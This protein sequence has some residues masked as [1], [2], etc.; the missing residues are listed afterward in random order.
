[1]QSFNIVYQ[2]RQF[3]VIDKPSG[4]SVHRDDQQQG[5]TIRIA[6]QLG[7]ERVWLVHRLDKATSGLLIF[8]LNKESARVLSELFAQHKIQK[9]YLALSQ[10]KPKKKQGRIIGDMEKSRRGQWKLCKTKENPAITD[11]ISY[12][13]EPNLR[14]FILKPKTGKTHQLRVAMKSLG[15]PILG[16][17]LYDNKDKAEVYDR[18][19]LH[20]YQLQFSAFGGEFNICCKPSYGLWFNRSSVMDKMLSCRIDE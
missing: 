13:C 15:S 8:A 7:I 2:H 17:M 11:F 18:M 19:Y 20:A 9:T 3:I 6:S 10:Q 16:D 1:M 4:I 14:L 12:G 5:L